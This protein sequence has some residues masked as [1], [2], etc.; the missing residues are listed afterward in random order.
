MGAGAERARRRMSERPEPMPRL[1]DM[2]PDGLLSR[3]LDSSGVEDIAT[4]LVAEDELG[5]WQVLITRADG[6]QIDLPKRFGT[7][8]GAVDYMYAWARGR[9]IIVTNPSGVLR[10]YV[11]PREDSDSVRFD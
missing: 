11:N 6:D 4:W 5:R 10:Q 3:L 7:V 1:S 9:G 2:D 8:G